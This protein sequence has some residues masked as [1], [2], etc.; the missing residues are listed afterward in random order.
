MFLNEMIY[1]KKHIFVFIVT[2]QEERPSFLLKMSI[3]S[4][5]PNQKAPITLSILLK[6]YSSIK[7][8]SI[9]YLS[10]SA[11]SRFVNN[12]KDIKENFNNEE[13]LIE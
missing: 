12:Y 1:L 9:L 2:P 3:F 4:N 10:S 5:W 11:V 13:I 6:K 7:L 8:N